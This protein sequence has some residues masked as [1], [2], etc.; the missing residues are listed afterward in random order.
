MTKIK[1]KEL[2]KMSVEDLNSKMRDLRKDLLKIN[3]QKST[4]TAIESPGRVKQV[5]KTIARILTILHAKSKETKK[6]EAKKKQ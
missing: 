5:K 2:A 6:T 4:G 1:A 3:A